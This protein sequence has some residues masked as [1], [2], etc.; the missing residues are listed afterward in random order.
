MKQVR[1]QALGLLQAAQDVVD[2]AHRQ[3]DTGS[4]HFLVPGPNLAALRAALEPLMPM[5]EYLRTSKE[6][7]DA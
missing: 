7:A 4:D 3:Y 6:A 2:N 1:D 5:L